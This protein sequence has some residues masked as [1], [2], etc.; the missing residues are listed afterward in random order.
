MEHGVKHNVE[1]VQETLRMIEEA[2]Y[3][4]REIKVTFDREEY[5]CII[6]DIAEEKQVNEYVTPGNEIIIEFVQSRTHTLDKQNIVSGIS[7]KGFLEVLNEWL[8]EREYSE[9]TTR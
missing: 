4:R 8:T 5:C 9:V 3:E 1:D 6:G 2:L 7:T